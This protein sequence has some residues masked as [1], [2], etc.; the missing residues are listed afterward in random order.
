MKIH[1]L[2]CWP[3]YYQAIIDGKKKFEYR[4]NDRIFRV[5]DMLRLEEWDPKAEYTDRA[6]AVSV[7]YIFPVADQHVIMSI[8]L[9][10]LGVRD[11]ESDKPEEKMSEPLTC[12]HCE[13]LVMRYSCIGCKAVVCGECL[14]DNPFCPNCGSSDEEN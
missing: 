7:D 9:Q 5:G 13:K 14:R 11:T 4:I 10:S 6:C 3:E 12:C 2:K 8:T 1:R